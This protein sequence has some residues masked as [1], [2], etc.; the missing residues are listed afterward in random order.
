MGEPV[1][2]T[3]TLRNM[4]GGTIAILPLLFPAYARGVLGGLPINI[5]SF[6]IT[7]DDR[8][9]PSLEQP[10]EWSGAVLARPNAWQLLGLRTGGFYGSRILLNQ[11]EW[12]H[13]LNDK[14][15]Y[16][17]RAR[18]ES[19]AREWFSRAPNRF[20]GLWDPDRVFTGVLESN[21]IE[22]EIH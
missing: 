7:R 17:I 12:A 22:I 20:D 1:A 2:V 13:K 4:G 14:G 10:G 9:V 3:V 19:D 11:G 8:P 5:L 6:R 16:S 18:F 21:S 15:R